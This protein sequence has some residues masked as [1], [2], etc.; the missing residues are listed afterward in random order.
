M[1]RFLAAISTVILGGLT[2]TPELG[3]QTKPDTNTV[4]IIRGIDSASVRWM[5]DTVR[6]DLIGRYPDIVV[7]DPVMSQVD[8][9][10]VRATRT[11][12]NGTR[13]YEF[14]VGYQ[15]VRRGTRWELTPYRTISH[16][17]G[18]RV[19]STKRKP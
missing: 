5:R 4:T 9:A 2:I 12:F 11:S 13:V 16:A 17:H 7:W 8:T 6:A 15:F 1:R 14:G 18:A 3:G 19:D 10:H